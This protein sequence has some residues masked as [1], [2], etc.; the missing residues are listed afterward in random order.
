[1]SIQHVIGIVSLV[2]LM[3]FWIWRITVEIS[4]SQCQ[5]YTHWSPQ[6]KDLSRDLLCCSSQRCCGQ[7]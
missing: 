6:R 5:D 1:M 7:G 4:Q 3:L 2:V